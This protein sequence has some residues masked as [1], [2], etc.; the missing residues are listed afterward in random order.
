MVTIFGRV[1]GSRVTSVLVVMLTWSSVALCGEIHDAVKN[2][3]SAKIR[4]LIKK[5]PDLVSSKDEDGF[6]PLHLAAVNGYRDLV[7]F[8]LTNKADVNSRDNAG[9]T[10]LHQA[11]AGEGD[12]SDLVELLLAQRAD[13]D[14]ADKHG[15]TPLHYAALADNQ[16]TIRSLLTHGANPNIKD[17]KYG[18][19]PLIIAVA[20]GNKKVA[21]LL[22]AHGADV[23]LADSDGTPL[24]WAT[25]TGH[26]DIADLLRKHGGHE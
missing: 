26:A 23:N 17:H 15:L 11:A 16:N 5:S 6:T 3:D 18:N 24:A 14:A 10:P 21:E 1:H 12:H 7:E 19:T 25:R 4:E 13:I 8:L 9:S 2:N 20:K 22:L